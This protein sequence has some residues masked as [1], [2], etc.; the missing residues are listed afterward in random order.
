MKQFK[1]ILVTTDLSPESFS[2]VSYAAHLAKAQDA[3]LAILHVPHTISLAYTEFVPPV[4]LVGIDDA[5]ERAA[6]EKLE[7]W[8]G[9]HV[10]GVSNVKIAVEN[11]VV[12]ETICEFAESWKASVIVIATHGRKG[13]GH[14]VLGSVAER[15]VR[16]APCPVLVVKPS[17]PAIDVTKK[18]KKKKAVK[19]KAG[20][21]KGGRSR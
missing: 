19:K 7:G 8:V 5:V 3:R 1:R 21:K 2:A 15:V 17:A 13:L 18:S 20:A 4:D 6:K 12:D 16:G 14:L 9:R 10:R 11:G